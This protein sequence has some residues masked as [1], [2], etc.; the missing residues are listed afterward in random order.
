MNSKGRSELVD[1]IELYFHVTAF[2]EDS[3]SGEDERP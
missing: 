3:A 2:R 1:D